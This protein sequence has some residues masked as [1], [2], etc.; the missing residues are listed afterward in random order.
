MHAVRRIS[1]VRN[2]IGSF[3]Y[4]NEPIRSSNRYIIGIASGSSGF[5]SEERM[6]CKKSDKLVSDQSWT[7]V[8]LD[9]VHQP[10]WAN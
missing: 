3:W 8:S 2:D 5:S 6:V 7:A 9:Y 1:N 4:G 10:L